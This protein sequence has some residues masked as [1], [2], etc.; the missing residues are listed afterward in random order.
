MHRTRFLAIIA[1]LFTLTIWGCSKPQA[2]TLIPESTRISTVTPKGIGVRITLN[3]N[4]PNDFDLMARGVKAT[5]VMGDKVKLGPVEVPHGISLPAKG[6]KKLK[7]DINATWEQAAQVAQLAS[8]GP[9]I[10]YVVEGTV[11]VGGKSLNV[12]LPFKINGEVS[13]TQLIAAGLK[14]LPS[15]PG[16]P[17]LK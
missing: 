3:A 9:T 11:K 8:G 16:L 12:D 1:T 13:Q 17:V 2:P 14:G 15:I 7:L 4:N 10:P 6:T 5:I